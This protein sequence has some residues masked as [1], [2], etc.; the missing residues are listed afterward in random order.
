VTPERIGPY[1]IEREIGRGGMGVVYLGRDTRLDRRIAIKVLPAAFAGDPERLAR[2]EREARL[3]A[4]LNHP[5]IAG[6]YGIEE[7]AGHRFLALEYVEG[8]TLAERIARGP[9]PLDE[10]LDV[11]RQVAA[12]LEAAHEGGVVHR[13]LKPANIKVTPAGEVKVL[14]FGLAKGGAAAGVESSSDLS[15]SPTLAIAATGAGMILGTAA[16]M[17]PEQARGKAVDKR[18]DIWAFGC[19]LYECLT[20]RQAFAGETVSD[21]IARILQGEPEWNAL[22]A[23]TPERVRGLLRRC[24]E[25]DARR[26][27]RDIGDARME[28]EDVQSVRASSSSIARTAAPAT[29]SRRLLEWGRLVAVALLAAAAA[30]F[31]PHGSRSPVRPQPARFTIPQPEG[32]F[33]LSDGASPVLSPDGRSLAFA[34]ADSSGETRMWLRNLESTVARPIAGTE[35][36]EFPTFWSPD[37][38]QIAFVSQ[39]KLKK[40]PVAG[41]EVEIICP[42]KAA[43]GGSWNQNGVI[44]IA[45]NSNGCIYRVPAAGGEPQ[46]V[47]TLDSTRGETAHRFPQFLPDG[48][49]FLYSVL[50]ARAGKF[51]TYIGTLDSPQRRLLLSAGCG[52]TWAPPGHLLFARDGKLFAQGFDAKALR[53]RGEPVSLG[54]AVTPTSRSG[55]PIA[56]A[57]GTGAV[58]YVTRQVTNQR[59]AWVDLAGHE[60]ASLP[61]APGPYFF[62]SLAPDDRRV[63]LTRSE[64]ADASDIWI[65]D[66]ERGVATRLTDEPG[67][68]EGPRWSPDGTRIAYTWSN[69]S[70]QVVKIR[71]LAGDTVTTLLESDPL[72]KR[73]HGWS[74]DGQSILY[75][76]LDPATQWDLWVLPLGGDRTPRPYLRTRFNETAGEISPDGRWIV[77]DSD[78]SGQVEA[79][80]QSFPTPGG[81]YQVTTGG[82]ANF[83]WSTDGRQL[84][85]GVSSDPLHGFAADVQAGGEFRLGPPRLAVTAPRDQRG[86]QIAHTAKRMLALFPAGKDP[87]PS[88]TVV[89]DALAGA[90][91]H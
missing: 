46:A 30:W 25:K 80:V 61:V 63:A 83:G 49:H 72:F 89:L 52:V 32:V 65:A 21:M 9:L 57:S 75:S 68:N 62:G 43:R 64:T 15:H 27:L 23:A 22:P 70:P 5:N 24:L 2:F 67:A 48:R 36:T 51:D 90:S 14:D 4:S 42:V 81:K 33:L 74:P 79:Y 69:N 45:P 77:Y 28:I 66:L 35:K 85:Y 16:Y 87:T 78:E 11:C 84:Y 20:G 40:V 71:S 73:F 10:T 47:T 41:G 31:A 82:G 59:L 29:G 76:R 12:A 50:P 8:E 55:G 3:V 7:D 91:K 18:T 39:E 38:R 53:L 17:S 26:R 86:L 6:I 54:D 13:D 34:A 37:G 58:A 60:T 56:S 44:L 1:P 88:I 19:L